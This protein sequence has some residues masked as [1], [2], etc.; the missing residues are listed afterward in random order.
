[1]L[2]KL[3]PPGQGYTDPLLV[4]K[5]AGKKGA[6]GFLKHTFEP[7]TQLI[8]LQNAKE[9]LEILMR[10]FDFVPTKDSTRRALRL[11]ENVACDSLLGRVLLR[12]SVLAMHDAQA[13]AGRG[14]CDAHGEEEARHHG[15]VRA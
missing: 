2:P 10:S 6:V 9:R 5:E 7:I 3:G 13:L 15:R 12:D 8:F 4:S 14:E 1:M 11:V